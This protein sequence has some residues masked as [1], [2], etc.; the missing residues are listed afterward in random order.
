M[1]IVTEQ[2]TGLARLNIVPEVTHRAKIHIQV[3][4]P[5]NLVLSVF[6]KLAYKIPSYS[7]DWLSKFL[8]LIS[9]GL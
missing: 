4:Q 9:K 3:G 7:Q 1:D 5:P 8:S 6:Q 2:E